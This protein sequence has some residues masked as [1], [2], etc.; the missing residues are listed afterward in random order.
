MKIA[1]FECEMLDNVPC[2]T[3]LASPAWLKEGA[4]V[5]GIAGAAC[6]IYE[7][8]FACARQLRP[9]TSPG[10]LRH[11]RIYAGALAE[12]CSSGVSLEGMCIIGQSCLGKG[13]YTISRLHCV[14]MLPSRDSAD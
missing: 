3:T 7:Y 6:M 9:I 12:E 8:V 5:V 11:F 14:C 1:A 10:F 13:G 2:N 4:K